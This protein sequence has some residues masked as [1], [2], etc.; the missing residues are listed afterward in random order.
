ME[1][2]IVYFRLLSKNNLVIT[3]A[4]L[5]IGLRL[6]NLV[7]SFWLCRNTIWISSGIPEDIIHYCGVSMSKSPSEIPQH[8]W[9]HHIYLRSSYVETYFEYQLEYFETSY[10]SPFVSF[11]NVNWML[12]IIHKDFIHCVVSLTSRHHLNFDVIICRHHTYL[13]KVLPYQSLCHLL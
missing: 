9:W 10:I 6:L 5:H 1:I 7:S 4:M 11:W 2:I 8:T 3:M 13:F 12:M